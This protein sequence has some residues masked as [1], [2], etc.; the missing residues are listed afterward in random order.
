MLDHPWNPK[1][2]AECAKLLAGEQYEPV[3]RGGLEHLGAFA[4]LRFDA[5]PS[6]L[7]SAIEQAR[8]LARDGNTQA[9]RQV[10]TN[11]AAEKHT[12]V[13]LGKYRDHVTWVERENAR[14]L[15]ALAWMWA[16]LREAAST[17]VALD[18]RLEQLERFAHDH[19]G[20]TEL[21]TTRGG[22]EKQ[23]SADYLLPQGWRNA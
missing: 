15:S 5:P 3:A 16:T 20:V 14:R 8:Q 21:L 7:G 9:A 12:A 23:T 4:P 17:D 13:D 2:N 18:R 6:W 22:A 11:A 19:Y 10:V 1:V